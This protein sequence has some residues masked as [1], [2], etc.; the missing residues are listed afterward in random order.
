VGRGGWLFLG[1]ERRGWSRGGG[2]GG[3]EGEGEGKDGEAGWG[4]GG[5]DEVVVGALW[6]LLSGGWG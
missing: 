5:E 4:R 3:G 2:G 6:W 1:G